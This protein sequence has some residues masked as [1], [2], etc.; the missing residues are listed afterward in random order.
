MVTKTF[1]SELICI[2]TLDYIVKNVKVMLLKYDFR[3]LKVYQPYWIVHVGRM[4]DVNMVIPTL[5]CL[6][7]QSCTSGNVWLGTW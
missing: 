3:L 5:R 4:S 7:L 6:V 2:S 1:F